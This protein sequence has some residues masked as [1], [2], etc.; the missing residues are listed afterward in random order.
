MR[1]FE[2]PQLSLQHPPTNKE[3]RIKMLI[4]P[5][6]DN[7]RTLKLFGMIQALETQMQTPTALDLVFEDRLGLLADAELSARENRQLQTRLKGAKLRQSASIEDVDLKV[8]RGLD[9]A[10]WST[11]ASSQWIPLHRNLSITGPTG[12]GKSFLACALA[13]KACRDG[14]TCLYE[15]A[16]RFFNDLAISKATGNYNKLLASISKKSLLVID[17]F[18]LAPLTD[19]QRRDLLEIMD[20]RYGKR[21]TLIASQLPLE[22]WHAMIGDPTIADAILD[23][24]VHNAHNI[25]LKTTESMRN[26]KRSNKS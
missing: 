9:R 7:L 10:L 20:D 15:R 16:S 3:R 8:P 22:H 21:S 25:V 11:L 1:M 2:A 23:R 12:G 14:Y 6:I 26:P 17:D 19:E 24:F 4:H 5:T 18:A 13:Q